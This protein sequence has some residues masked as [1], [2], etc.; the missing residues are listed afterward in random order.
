MAVN[1][2]DYE[3]LQST[4]GTLSASGLH[5]SRLSLWR[6]PD[7]A[8]KAALEESGNAKVAATAAQE[9]TYWWAAKLTLTD[10]KLGQCF[11]EGQI[12]WATGEREQ[13]KWREVVP[14]APSDDVSWDFTELA[15]IG[16]R[17]WA[18]AALSK[19]RVCLPSGSCAGCDTAQV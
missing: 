19:Q 6:S 17:A 15:P 10:A 5:R 4:S 11:R 16:L 18:H 14:L 13:L 7:R 2:G 8:V 3:W 1:V 12:E 9:T